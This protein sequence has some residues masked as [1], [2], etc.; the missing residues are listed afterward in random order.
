MGENGNLVWR[1][2]CGAEFPETGDRKGFGQLFKHARETGHGMR[3]VIGLIDLDTGEL[4]IKGPDMRR[5][6]AMGLVQPKEEKVAAKSGKAGASVSSSTRI[7][8]RFQDVELDPSLWILFDLARLKW[9]EEYD[10]TPESFAQWVAECCYY[11][12]MEHAEELGFDVLLAK[13]IERLRQKQ[14]EAV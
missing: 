8:M 2:E 1:C 5:A 7:K 13:S 6:V 9:P 11:F 14:E 4:V 3:G 12:Y 10:D